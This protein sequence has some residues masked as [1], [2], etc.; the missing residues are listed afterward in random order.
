MLGSM[1]GGH[2]EVRAQKKLILAPEDQGGF[3]R[4]NMDLSLDGKVGA[5]Q[6]EGR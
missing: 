3:Q 2:H 1:E 5:G 4:K 6:E